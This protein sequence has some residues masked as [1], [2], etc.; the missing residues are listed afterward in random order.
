MLFPLVTLTRV[1]TFPLTRLLLQWFSKRPAPSE[2]L[3]NFWQPHPQHQISFRKSRTVMTEQS[4]PPDGKCD[5]AERNQVSNRQ[6]AQYFPSSGSNQGNLGTGQPFHWSR[7]CTVGTL[8]TTTSF[9]CITTDRSD[10][11]WDC[12]FFSIIQ[13]V[14]HTKAGCRMKVKVFRSV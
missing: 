6:T 8:F 5:R 7:I 2:L 9:K 12:P 13:L 3:Y 1:S 14:T 10:I 11:Y 4:I